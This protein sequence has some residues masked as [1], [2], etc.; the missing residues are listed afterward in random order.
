MYTIIKYLELFINKLTM[1]TILSFYFNEMLQLF[2][3]TYF[4]FVKGL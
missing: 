2:S 1:F 3:L 4:E